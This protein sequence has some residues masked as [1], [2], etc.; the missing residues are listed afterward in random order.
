[1]IK[2][3]IIKEKPLYEVIIEV[4]KII[5]KEIPKEIIKVI[6]IQTKPK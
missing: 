4:L 3:E 2:V 6:R 1:M 5:T